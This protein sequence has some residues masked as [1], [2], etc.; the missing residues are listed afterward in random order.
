MNELFTR[1]W[2]LATIIGWLVLILLDELAYYWWKDLNPGS[3]YA[4]IL[5]K[6][7]LTPTPA[8]SGTGQANGYRPGGV[9]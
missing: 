9:Y 3:Q 2:L 5:V 6:H 1:K 8:T 7:P 4:G